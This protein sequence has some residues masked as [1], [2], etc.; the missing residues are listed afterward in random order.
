MLLGVALTTTKGDAMWALELQPFVDVY[1]LLSAALTAMRTAGWPS[2]FTQD[3]FRPWRLE[4]SDIAGVVDFDRLHV[5]RQGLGAAAPPP[6]PVA[7]GGPAT[8]RTVYAVVASATSDVLSFVF[9]LVASVDDEVVAE[10]SSAHGTTSLT[11]ALVRSKVAAAAAAAGGG[12]RPGPGTGGFA[13]APVSVSQAASF[14][15]A[16]NDAIRQCALGS[17]YV[18]WSGDAVTAPPEKVGQVVPT[19]AARVVA[20]VDAFGTPNKANL[21]ELA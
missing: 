9:V 12:P 10:E 6:A 16:M 8:A 4:A 17:D 2:S 5:L 14:G 18:P 21:A 15:H 20:M 3:D 7:A 19:I 11:A 1:P 13:S